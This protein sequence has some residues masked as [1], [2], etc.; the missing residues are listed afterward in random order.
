LQRVPAKGCGVQKAF[1]LGAG[2]GTR[3]KSLTEFLPKPLIPV[4]QRPLISFAFDHLMRAGVGE[5]VVNTHHCAGAY[6]EHFPTSD[7][8]GAPITFRHEPVLLET[9]GG[10]DNVAD[11]LAGGRFVVYNGDI[12]T[13]LP[14]AEASAAHEASGNVVTLVLR[15]SG[16]ARHIAL[17]RESGAVTDI[18][19]L[20]GTGD[21]GQFQ[22]T[23]I[24]IC[25]PEFLGWLRHGEKHSVI[26]VF[27]EM[28][29][30]GGGLGGVVIDRG[31]WWD[32][33]SRETYLAAHMAVAAPGFPIYD[34][35]GTPAWKARVHG[36]AE[37]SASASVDAASCVG[38][39]ARI[40]RLAE[41]RSTV[42]WPGGEVAPG[43]RLDHCIVRSGRVASGVLN[44]EDI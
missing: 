24:Y 3:L 29:R 11:L 7:F 4:Y 14:L 42:V 37:V 13:D 35:A 36:A 44:N 34:P 17:H 32:L 31:D 27:L 41:L 12:L 19:N 9:G 8:G 6:A 5:F 26:P 38:A 15:S 25:E 2:L 40:G 18:R 23:G 20:A 21:E 33:G 10:I 39:G 1:V 22:F 16:P 28:I 30:S 43:A